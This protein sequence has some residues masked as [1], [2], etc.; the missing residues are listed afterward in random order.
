[1]VVLRVIDALLYHVLA[2]AYQ[3]CRRDL[4][5]RGAG[6][7]IL[8]VAPLFGQVIGG[9]FFCGLWG[10]MIRTGTSKCFAYGF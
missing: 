10:A 1:M 5:I 6:L 2:S 4:S 7:M 3:G 8:Q 9:D